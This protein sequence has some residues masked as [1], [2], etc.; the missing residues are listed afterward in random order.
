MIRW[1]KTNQDVLLIVAVSFV[2]RISFVGLLHERGYT[3]D[4]NEYLS[5]A[6]KLSEGKEFVDSNGEWSTKAP[7]WPFVLSVLLRVFGSGLLMPHL[8]AC[9]LGAFTV[10][11]GFRLCVE[12]L[13]DRFVALIAASLLAV[14]PS[15]IVY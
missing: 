15:L 13:E 2:L 7:L 4:E 8:V 6:T 9:L 14:Y 11:L 1:L 10:Y 3:S 5:L 12:L